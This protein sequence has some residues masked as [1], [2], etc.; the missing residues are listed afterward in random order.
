MHCL[1][2]VPGTHRVDLVDRP[3]PGLP[4]EGE[5]L[6]EM[7]ECG[8]C[9]TD[10]HI[11][12]GD[13]VRP[14][15]GQAALVLGHEPLGRVL[16]AGTG[17][18]G[19]AAGDLVTATNQRSCGLCAPCASGEVD[20]CLTAAGR[21]RGVGGLDGFLRPRL[22]DDA[23]FCVRVPEGL[24]EVAVLTEPL[25][26]GQKAI[27]QARQTQRR[28]PGTRWTEQAGEPEWAAGL[29]FAVGGAGPVGMLIAIALRCHGGE[30]HV[31]DRV[32]A[33]GTKAALV[34]ACGAHYHCTS[35][36]D[37]AGLAERLGH[38][39]CAIEASGSGELLI[40]LW[41][42]L[43]RNGVLALVGG[44]G[45]PLAPVHPGHLLGQALVRNQALVG[46]VASNP[47]HFR[48]ALADLAIAQM[49][50]PAAIRGI[51]TARHAFGEAAGAFGA[52]GSGDVKSVIRI[53]DL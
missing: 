52:V 42:A 53:A 11:I 1:G 10:R 22:L 38:L 12:Q 31:L 5:V 36:M 13:W 25:A 33:D 4:G 43:G 20:L 23:A 6:I 16:R 44:G 27:E 14:E 47:R 49:R 29:R 15:P 17:V 9:G 39:D 32:P 51:V 48:A 50:Y 8:V 3:E 34:A 2:L 7:L 19:L 30:V 18:T 24:A 40:A 28:L 37:L 26:V 35:G 46:I 21:G 41:R 45:G